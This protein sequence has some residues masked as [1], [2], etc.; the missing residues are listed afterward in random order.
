LVNA[1]ELPS[2]RNHF[3]HFGDRVSQG[4][5]DLLLKRYGLEEEKKVHL[6]R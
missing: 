1:E 6:L 2:G 4:G 5:L 3:R